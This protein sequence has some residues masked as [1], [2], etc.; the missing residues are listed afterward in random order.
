M[1]ENA[2][3]YSESILEKMTL[4]QCHRCA[5]CTVCNNYREQLLRDAK[6]FNLTTHP[7]MQKQ[8]KIFKPIPQHV[9][10][11]SISDPSTLNKGL[12]CQPDIYYWEHLRKTVNQIPHSTTIKIP[13]SSHSS[14]PLVRTDVLGYSYESKTT[15]SCKLLDQH[16]N[17]IE[18]ANE[19]MCSISESCQKLE[20]KLAVLEESWKNNMNHTLRNN[21]SVNGC[22]SD[23]APTNQVKFSSDSFMVNDL[24]SEETEQ[25]MTKTNIW[26]LH[27][28]Q[29]PLLMSE[30][31]DERDNELDCD[32]DQKKPTSKI[33]VGGSGKSCFYAF[34]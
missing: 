13:A 21:E 23:S 33:D 2:L 20:E 31:M 7:K 10:T 16:N 15:N 14:S 34:L 12:A 11:A 30:I 32:S 26:S 24:V 17:S 8:T 9:N 4:S 5:S 25:S 1:K 22:L 6:V 3:Q 27:K 19:R 29:E 28:K 18:Q